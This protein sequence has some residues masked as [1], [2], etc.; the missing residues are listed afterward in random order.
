MS[1]KLSNGSEFINPNFSAEFGEFL[2]VNNF[3]CQVNK[4]QIK[5]HSGDKLLV[6]INDQVDLYIF[7]PEEPGQETEK[8]VYEQSH[9]GIS[10][11]NLFG[12]IFL[13]H[14]MGILKISD[15][16]SNAK[17]AG[18]QTATEAD[19]ILKTAFNSPLQKVS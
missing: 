9:I 15:F 3:S 14:I 16:V 5:F 1:T 18:V 13:M 11:F 4:N 8:W 17:R 2:L 12:W 19:F 7:H 6:V 10:H